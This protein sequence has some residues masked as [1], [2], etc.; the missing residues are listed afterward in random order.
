MKPRVL[1]EDWG[2]NRMGY[3]PFSLSP[4]S[5]TVPVRL[6][7]IV[8]SI[9]V[10]ANQHLLSLQNLLIESKFADAEGQCRILERRKF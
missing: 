6:S 4:W 2:C 7:F 5:I 1:L 8:K 3:N 10:G 9:S